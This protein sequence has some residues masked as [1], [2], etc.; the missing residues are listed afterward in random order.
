MLEKLKGS[1]QEFVRLK[2][3][4]SPPSNRVFDETLRAECAI[5]QSTLYLPSG[6]CVSLP[7]TLKSRNAANQVNGS[8]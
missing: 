6:D 4:F 3:L 5:C 8:G 1:E 2:D 7:D